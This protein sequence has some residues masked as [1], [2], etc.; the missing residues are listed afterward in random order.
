[1]ESQKPKI[2]MYVKRNFGEK[3]SASFDFIKENWKLMLKFTTYLLLPI[4]LIQALSLNGLMGY[5]AVLTDLSGGGGL[6]D[7]SLMMSFFSYYSL[8]M[9]VF[10]IG[11][12]AL[13]S[14]IYAL[15]RTY[16][17]RD[18]RLQGVTL[19]MLRPML[20]RNVK[21]LVVMTLFGLVLMVLLGVIM[22]LMAALLWP[23]LFLVIP[24][25]IILAVPLALWA[26]IY[27]FEDISVME[28]LKKTFRLGFATWGGIFLISLIMGLIAGI[29]QG[30]TMMPWYIGTIVKSIFAMSSGGSEATVSVGYNFMLYL[31]AIVQAFGAYLAMIFSLVGLAYQYGHASEKVDNIMVE[32]DIDNFD[33]L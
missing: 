25:V 11:T 26:P 9:F 12:I 16:N 22:G 24:F 21:R 28:S 17:E 31:L 8:Y 15:I 27:L 13:T 14:L 23:A 20:L 1:M 4:C 5:I 18:E 30:V 32:S 2:A 19:G 6:S 10:L 7:A 29:L 33:K 3:L